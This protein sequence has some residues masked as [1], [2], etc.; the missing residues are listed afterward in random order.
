MISSQLQDDLG[1]ADAALFALADRGMRVLL[2]LGPGH[3]R[4]ELLRVPPKRPRRQEA[5]HALRVP[6]AGS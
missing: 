4:S 2:T 1:L 6:S 5:A 3:D